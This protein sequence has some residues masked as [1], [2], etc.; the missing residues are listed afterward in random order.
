MESWHVLHNLIPNLWQLVLAKIPVEGLVV[1]PDKHGL[2]YDPGDTLGLL[3]H[4]G[5]I[6]QCN[7]VTFDVGMVMDG[8]GDS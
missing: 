1:E 8:E 3:V 5:K 7:G 6:V 2:F 4:D